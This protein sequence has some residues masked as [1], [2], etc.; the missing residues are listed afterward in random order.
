MVQF[1]KKKF[2]YF[3]GINERFL[4]LSKNSDSEKKIEQLQ[5]QFTRLTDPSGMGGLIK[6]VLITKKILN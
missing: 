2:L 6:C 4:M 5:S 1:L 3:N